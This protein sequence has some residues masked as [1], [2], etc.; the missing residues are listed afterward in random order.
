[1]NK[2][3][4]LLLIIA[5]SLLMT[6][7]EDQEKNKLDN[8][9]VDFWN[10]KIDHNFKEAYKYLSPGWR[11][12]ES[13]LAYVARMNGGAIKW[14]AASVKEK[15][16]TEVYLCNIIMNIEYE[17]KFKGAMA[18]KIQ[19]ETNITESWLMKNNIW[20]HVPNEVKVEQ[21]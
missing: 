5:V 7:C 11:S 20:Y 19:I 3:K 12:N 16:C 4:A 9:V 8:R 10:Y 21:K 2:I 17:Y 15:N 6:A 13:E 1:M 14:L 18:N